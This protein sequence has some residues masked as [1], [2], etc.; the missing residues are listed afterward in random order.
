MG[1]LLSQWLTLYMLSLFIFL[2]TF[3]SSNSKP[4]FLSIDVCRDGIQEKTPFLLGIAQIPP[5]PLPRV[6]A[7]C[8]KN[9]K[10]QI[11]FWQPKRKG[12]FFG[13]LSPTITNFCEN[14]SQA[15]QC[16]Y[17]R[18]FHKVN[19]TK[20]SDNRQDLITPIKTLQQ[21]CPPIRGLHLRYCADTER[22]NPSF[23]RWFLL[24]I[25]RKA[26]F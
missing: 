18:M 25:K 16:Q 17:H 8:H 5:P 19:G 10:C 13:T 12:V 11:Q 3:N 23:L 6:W 21:R 1:I 14:V 22:G 4:C 7:T 15:M 9:G 2:R 24:Q 20:H 26:L